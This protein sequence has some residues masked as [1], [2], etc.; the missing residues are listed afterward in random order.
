MNLSFH[1][2]RNKKSRMQIL[3]LVNSLTPRNQYIINHILG[4]MLS[5]E[6]KITENINELLEHQG[7]KINYTDRKINQTI[8]ITPHPLLSLNGIFEQS[9]AFFYWKSIPAFFMTDNEADIP[10]D[11]FAASFYLITRY[12]EYFPLETDMHGRFKVAYS[13]AFRNGFLEVPIVDLWV[14]ELGEMIKQKYPNVKLEEKKFQF[15]PTIDI[16]N[17][18]AFKHKGLVR[19]S[20]GSARSLTKLQI[21]DLLKRTAVNLN[22]EYDPFDTYDELMQIL[23]DKP[24]SVWFILGGE[25]GSY[26]KNVPLRKK[27]MR[28]LVKRIANRYQ[29]GVHPSYGAETSFERVKSELDALSKVINKKVVASRQHFLRLKLPQTYRL[30]N[31]LGITHDY[32]MGYSNAIGFRASTCTPFRFYDLIDEKE[33]PLVVVPFQVMDR[34]LLDGLKYNARQ[35]VDR[36]L[37]IANRVCKV[38]GIFVTIWHNESLSGINEW[39]GWEKV[40]SEIVWGVNLLG[41]SES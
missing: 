15:I 34:A 33:L 37:E 30:L 13:I 21:D 40:F 2:L 19:T 41:N 36:T 39:E 20:L 18:F 1:Y 25:Y 5:F 38:G 7:L 35:A 24:N 6:V 4:K 23:K 16:D 12:E 17:A 29:V 32:S 26:D 14:S 22:L 11:I 10:F 27:S 28:K 31:E 8:N 9:F 3:V